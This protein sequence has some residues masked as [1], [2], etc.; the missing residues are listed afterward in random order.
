[1]LGDFHLIDVFAGAGGLS[2]G[3]IREGF[4]PVAF[5][6]KEKHSCNTLKTRVAYWWLKNNGDLGTYREYLKGVISREDLYSRVNLPLKDIV[7]KA[8]ISRDTVKSIIRKIRRNMEEQGVNCIHVLLGAPP[9]QS[10]SAVGKARISLEK[11]R[12]DPRA[13][14]YLH[15]IKMVEVFR[16]CFFVFENVPAMKVALKGHILRNMRE[17][18]KDLGYEAETKILNARKYYVLQKRKRIFIVGWPKESGGRYPDP[19]KKEHEYLVADVLNDLPRLK[20]GEGQNVMDY[21]GEPNGYLRSSGIRKNWN[22]L[23]HHIARPHN[24][25]DIQIYKRAI[26]MW[27]EKRKRL[28]YIDLPEHLQTHRNRTSFLDRFK[29]VADNKQYSHT[30]VAHIAKDGHYYIHP[31]IDQTRSLTAREAARLQSFPDNFYFE[32]PRTSRYR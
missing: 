3:F 6:D 2:E 16:P 19:R 5:V 4:H 11:A 22:I 17:R 13:F 18:I 10:Y 7:I 28:K 29:V 12:V 23:T 20:P 21:D 31:D 32:G 24:S 26:K 30:M 25:R 8:E 1:M 15:F 14:L 9:C 27:K